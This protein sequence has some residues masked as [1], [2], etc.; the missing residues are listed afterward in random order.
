MLKKFVN[1]LLVIMLII[2]SIIIPDAKVKGQTLGDVERELEQYKK[3]YEE[4]KLNQEKTE[5]EINSTKQSIANY[6]QEIVNTSNEIIKLNEEIANL[7]IE[8]DKKNEEIKEI[9]NFFQKSNGESAY[10]EYAFGAKDFTDFIYRVA[11]SEQLAK[12]NQKLISEYEAQIEENNQKTKELDEK[13]KEL[14]NKQK[15]LE[16]LLQSLNSEL[17]TYENE[18]VSIEEEIR[19]KE[20]A[21]AM[22]KEMGCES[23]DDLDIC[24]REKLPYTTELFRPLK[25]GY[26]T[27][28]F[29]YPDND[30]SHFYSFHGAID[31]STV[32]NNTPVYAAGDGLVVAVSRNQS[33]GSNIV[34]IQ[35][36][37]RNNE[38]YTTSY[39]HLRKVYVSEGDVV[40]KDTQIGI[41]GGARSDND[42]CSTGA[43][44]HFVI[45][46]GLYLQDY[47]YIS[48]FNSRRINPRMLVNFPSKYV[49]FKDRLIK[50]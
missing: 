9:M 19:M 21:I 41:M 33:C 23:D 15:E 11:V 46:T 5:E 48:T 18:E 42:R 20:D 24:T 34:Y 39:W 7:N 43:H 26:V 16:K 27:Q 3:D 40:T 31:V 22:Y 10:L 36:R 25:V 17:A 47:Y 45:A 50:Y 14:N 38:T 35:H 2:P 44:V 8:I 12:Y 37:L 13:K 32:D 4:N 49:T 28:E 30:T 1:I 6:N 29:G